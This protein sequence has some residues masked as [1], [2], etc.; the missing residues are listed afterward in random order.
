MGSYDLLSRFLKHKE[1]TM[2]R[3]L[4]LLFSWDECNDVRQA[5]LLL[6]AL[7]FDQVR[8]YQIYSRISANVYAYSHAIINHYTY[9]EHLTITAFIYLTITITNRLFR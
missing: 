4:V 2:L 8:I 9:Q 5:E 3:F 1:C 7:K 6:K